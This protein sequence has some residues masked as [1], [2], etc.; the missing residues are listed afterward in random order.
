MRR[1]IGG[2]PPAPLRTFGVPPIR[3]LHTAA[4]TARWRSIAAIV[5]GTLAVQRSEIAGGSDLAGPYWS[6]SSCRS[7]SILHHDLEAVGGVAISLMLS[8]GLPST[9][10]DPRAHLFHGEASMSSDE[11]TEGAAHG[12]LRDRSRQSRSS[13]LWRRCPCGALGAF[14]GAEHRLGVGLPVL[15]GQVHVDVPGLGV[16]GPCSS[17]GPRDGPGER[18]APPRRVLLMNTLRMNDLQA[19]HTFKGIEVTIAMQEFMT[20]DKQNVAIQQSIDL[21]I[22]KPRA[23]KV[24]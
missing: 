8:S 7:S 1:T 15:L 11:P 4:L 16:H 23:R 17:P 6:T 9:A 14:V 5:L 18:Q 10:A 20:R 3:H 21:R 24:R 2:S 13:G 22:V 19:E 12:Q